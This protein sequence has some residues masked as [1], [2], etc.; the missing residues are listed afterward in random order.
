[1]FITCYTLEENPYLR[2]ARQLR[3]SRKPSERRIKLY[4]KEKTPTYKL[5][6]VEYDSWTGDFTYTYEVK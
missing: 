3:S 4:K 1:M 6:E 5:T 2:A